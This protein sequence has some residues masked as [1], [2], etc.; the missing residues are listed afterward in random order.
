MVKWVNTLGSASPSPLLITAHPF[1]TALPCSSKAF[2]IDYSFVTKVVSSIQLTHTVYQ[3]EIQLDLHPLQQIFLF[4]GAFKTRCVL[5]LQLSWKKPTKIHAEKSSPAFHPEVKAITAK[6][7]VCISKHHNV[8][9]L[10]YLVFNSEDYVKP[11]PNKTQLDFSWQANC[12]TDQKSYFTHCKT[13]ILEILQL[14]WFR[15]KAILQL[16]KWEYFGK[17]RCF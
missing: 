12:W 9:V 6:P 2:H 4:S 11:N 13:E 14:V 3:H 16:Y 8:T 1:A 5:H 15:I 17:E 10:V 7:A